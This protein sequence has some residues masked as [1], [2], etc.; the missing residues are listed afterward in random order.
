ME[1]YRALGLIGAILVIVIGL[2]MS[3]FFFRFYPYHFGMMGFGMMMFG[4]P[5]FFALIP[6]VMGLIGALI[7]DKIASGVLLIIA[8]FLSLPVFFGAFGIG[9]V[10]MLVGGIL[11]LTSKS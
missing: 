7:N 9:F 2:L 5:F 11:A 3:I 8:S 10:L 6:G 1:T 4:F